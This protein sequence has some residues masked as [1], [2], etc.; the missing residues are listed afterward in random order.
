MTP[1]LGVDPQPFEC[2][3][4][5]ATA[6]PGRVLPLL[7][8]VVT[9]AACSDSSS[10]VASTTVPVST[11]APVSTTTAE[12]ELLQP[13][14]S[15]SLVF[16]WSVD[17]D[18]TL[19]PAEFEVVDVEFD[20]V[21]SPA[22]GV[23]ARFNGSSS[24]AMV[25]DHDTVDVGRLQ[26]VD[27]LTVEFWFRADPAEI[28]VSPAYLARWRWYGWG[29][30]ISDG[31]LAADVWQVPDGG[32]P[33]AITLAGGA[34]DDDWHHLALVVDESVVQLYLDGAIVDDGAAL[35][36]V[37]YVGIAPEDDCCGIGGALGFGR[38]ADVDGN[39]F[40]GWMDGIALHDRALD[41]AT[42][43]AHAAG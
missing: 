38:D 14:A 30:R 9:A 32:E 39:Y 24:R 5:G 43:A 15:E 22:G 19:T 26:P 7:V 27:E 12:V 25:A 10:V 41:A 20:D 23:A 11:T 17:D 29:V 18:P 28:T 34:V 8:L 31:Q 40:A 33:M 37:Y 6:L 3:R 13:V 36:P 35:G 4:R 21:D 42:V 16:G 1:G 2:R